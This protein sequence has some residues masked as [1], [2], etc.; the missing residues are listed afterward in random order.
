MRAHGRK[1]RANGSLDCW[2]AGSAHSA[3]QQN[4]PVLAD[5][6]SPIAEGRS[7][8]P[9]ELASVAAV[10]DINQQPESKPD[11][12]TQPRDDGES[13]HQADA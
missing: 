13:S 6:S 9:R 10:E 2:Q 4:Q 5:R 11:Y 7:L 1:R 3:E 8:L 12:E